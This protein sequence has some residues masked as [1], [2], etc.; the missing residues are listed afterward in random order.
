MI[1]LINSIFIVIANYVMS[2]LMVF[3][4]KDMVDYN[5]AAK[6]SAEEDAKDA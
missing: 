5:Q 1:K 4:E 6:S 2:K 3:K